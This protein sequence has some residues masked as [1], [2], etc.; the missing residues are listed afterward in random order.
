MESAVDGWS[1][2]MIR[3][4]CRWMRCVG[5]S[6]DRST[7]SSDDPQAG[8][9]SLPRHYFILLLRLQMPEHP[10]TASRIG[11]SPTAS[12]PPYHSTSSSLHPREGLLH[13]GETSD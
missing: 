10:Q 13:S 5:I 12:P 11:R 8:G 2:L 4:A 1:P 3:P 9:T 7:L 6:R